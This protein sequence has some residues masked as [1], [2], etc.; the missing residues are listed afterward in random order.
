MSIGQK[1]EKLADFERLNKLIRYWILEMTTEAG[2]G[3]PTSSLSAVEIMTT[4]MFTSTRTDTDNTQTNTENSESVFFRYDI[5][6]PEN[7]NNDRLIFSKGHASPLYYALWAAAGAI[8]PEEL[9][10]FRKFGSRLE[11]HPTRAFPFTEVPTGSL[12]QG[13]GVGL[14]I[15]LASRGHIRTECG[16]IQNEENREQRTENRKQ[17]MEDEKQNRAEG[18]SEIQQE[19]THHSLHATHRIPKAFVLLGDSEMAEG[20]VWEAVQLAAHYK[21]NN[22][23]GIL[24]VNRLGQ[25]GETMYGHDIES[26]KQKL[27]AF[28]WCAVCVD[29]H[30]SEEIS[31]AYKQAMQETERPTMIIAKTMKGKGV[32]FLEN[33]NGWHGKALSEEEF[34]RAKEELGEIHFNVRGKIQQSVMSNQQSVVQNQQSDSSYELQ[35]TNYKLQNMIATRKVY[36]KA[37]IE[38]GKKNENIVVLDAEVSNSTYAAGFQEVFPERFFEMFIAEQNMIST[39][40]GMARREKIPFVSSFGAFLT[41]AFDQIRMAQYAGVNMVV[42]GSHVGVSIG[43]DGASQ[44]GLEDLA[45]FRSLLKSTVLYPSDAVSMMKL[46]E[47]ASENKGITYVRTT[48]AETPVLYSENEQFVVGGSKTLKESEED[49]VTLVTAGVTLPEAL[50]AAEELNKEDIHVRVIDLYSVKPVDVETLKKAAHETRSIITI[51]DHY[52]E[53]GVGAAVREAL[54]D[55]RSNV[56]SLAVTKI[57]RSGTPEELLRY[58][59][60]DA[61]A[62]VRKVKETL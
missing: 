19:I 14:G 37:L 12:G 20:S 48:R 59:D 25:R 40:V 52:P 42:V 45:V 47:L 7:P 11:G 22:L 36:G 31:Q 38:I 13:L 49:Q 2:S 53:G 54:A 29:G 62:I 6:N 44:M 57:P 24:D 46:T 30:E 27:E 55:V 10:E 41:R 43:E 26:Y 56:H 9:L 28:G 16:L 51:E 8:R 50:K 33:E 34:E 39:A 3:H 58:E 32:S 5:N 35:V 15:A 18:D 21:C 60:I 1:G 23:I 17:R 4:L 61:Q